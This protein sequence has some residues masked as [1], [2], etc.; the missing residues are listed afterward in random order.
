MNHVEQVFCTS[1]SSQLL[2]V[3]Q[4][5]CVFPWT[6]KWIGDPNEALNSALENRFTFLSGLVELLLIPVEDLVV[7]IMI[8]KK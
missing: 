1:S 8:F 6:A 7:V 3:T 5:H 2:V 4:I